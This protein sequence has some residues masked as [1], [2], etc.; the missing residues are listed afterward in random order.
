MLTCSVKFNA[1]WLDLQYR[2]ALKKEFGKIQFYALDQDALLPVG[3]EKRYLQ[4]LRYIIEGRAR[5]VNK[6]YKPHW[7][8]GLYAVDR[9]NRTVRL[10][11]EN[12]DSS[13]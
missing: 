9:K 8:G 4:M 2:I 6:A 11:R 1:K 10:V 5:K 7:G 12:F 3:K 13:D